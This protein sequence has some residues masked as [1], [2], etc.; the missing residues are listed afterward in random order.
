MGIHIRQ[1]RGP[2]FGRHVKQA[3]RP[4][5]KTWD[6]SKDPGNKYKLRQPNC[7]WGEMLSKPGPKKCKTNRR[8]LRRNTPANY[9]LPSTLSYCLTRFSDKLRLQGLRH[10]TKTTTTY[11][12]LLLPL[13]TTT[14]TTTTTLLP[15]SS[16]EF[17]DN[18]S[19]V[20]V[21]SRLRGLPCFTPTTTLR[22]LT[23]TT[24]YSLVRLPTTTTLFICT[25]TTNYDYYYFTTTLIK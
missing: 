4:W 5:G 14:T 11:Y 9:Q 19:C 25:T 17:Q 21:I 6:Q 22:L 2:W 16:N 3:T 13:L 1:V 15:P 10:C 23:T 7:P 8:T 24:T 12:W 18:P 20:Q